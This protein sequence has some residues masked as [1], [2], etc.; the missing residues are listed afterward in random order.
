MYLWSGH[1]CLR[2]AITSKPVKDVRR[3]SWPQEPQGNLGAEV[4]WSVLC[5]TQVITLKRTYDLVHNTSFPHSVLPPLAASVLLGLHINLL[6]F[7][8]RCQLWNKRNWHE[9]L[10]FPIVNRLSSFPSF[11]WIKDLFC[12]LGKNSVISTRMMIYW[13]WFLFLMDSGNQ[14]YNL[15]A[16]HHWPATVSWNDST[17]LRYLPNPACN[18]TR[19]YNINSKS[20]FQEG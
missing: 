12:L 3:D 5:P 11:H 18:H 20:R 8:Q 14:S 10:I 4:G 13:R 1:D 17:K 9:A 19:K 2:E 6:I 16:C 15:L 7:I